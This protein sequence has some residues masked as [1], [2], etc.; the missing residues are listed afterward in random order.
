[1]HSGGGG[2][3]ASG[4]QQ[5]NGGAN[6]GPVVPPETNYTF[7]E[8]YEVEVTATAHARGTLLRLRQSGMA[9]TPEERVAGTLDCRCRWIYYLAALKSR[10][11]NGIDLRDQDP[12]TG[13]SYSVGFDRG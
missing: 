11:E 5:Q 12:R 6:S 10:L 9:D 3:D 7:G 4:Q 8:G 13:G 2:V 1:M